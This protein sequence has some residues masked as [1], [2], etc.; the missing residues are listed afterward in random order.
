M[1]TVETVNS[2]YKESKGTTESSAVVVG[3]AF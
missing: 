3:D 2:M 1:L